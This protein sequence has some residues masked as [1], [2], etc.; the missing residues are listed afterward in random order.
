[1]NPPETDVLLPKVGVRAAP[2]FVEYEPLAAV[3]LRLTPSYPYNANVY[4]VPGERPLK[5]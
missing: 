1:V 4:D 5:V 2:V 3:V